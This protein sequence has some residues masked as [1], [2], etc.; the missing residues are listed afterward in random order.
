MLFTL[1]SLS[2]DR[3][4]IHYKVIA[5]VNWWN[6]LTWG[7]HPLWWGSMPVDDFLDILTTFGTYVVEN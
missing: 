4:T 1:M 6:P 3:R 2:E 7:Y 5:K